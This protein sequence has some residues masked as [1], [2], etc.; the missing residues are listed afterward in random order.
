M[1]LYGT[2]I[3]TTSSTAAAAAQV[4]RAELVDVAD[5]SHDRAGQR[6]GSR[7]RPRPP[8]ARDQRSRS[9]LPGWPRGPSP[10]PSGPPVARRNI[11]PNKKTRAFG[12]GL[13]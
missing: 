8:C 6:R 10:R 11:A 1:S 9:H 2:E 4:E 3:R 5:Q 13:W 7:R 12:P